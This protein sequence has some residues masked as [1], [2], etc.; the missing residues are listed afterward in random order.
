MKK[1]I[2]KLVTDIS[3]DIKR[4]E[5]L[6]RYQKLL[7]SGFTK[8]A[9]IKLSMNLFTLYE[10]SEEIDLDRRDEIEGYIDVIN[11]AI[12]GIYIDKNV[13]GCVGDVTEIRDIITHRMKILT[14]YTDA[15][16]IYEYILN[17]REP[18][19]LETVDESIDTDPGLCRGV[20]H[21]CF[22]RLLRDSYTA[23]CVGV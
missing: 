11:Q 22:H 18:L 13:D 16:E 4:E 21:Y 9:T 10:M 15:L 23:S 1:E 5:A 12:R 3:A 14:A 17:R 19:I 7:A 2:K 6:I 20:Q 8:Y